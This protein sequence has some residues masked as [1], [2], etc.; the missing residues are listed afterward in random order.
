M[1][2]ALQKSPTIA[3]LSRIALLLFD[4]ARRKVLNKDNLRARL[5]SRADR[6][7]SKVQEVLMWVYLPRVAPKAWATCAHGGMAYPIPFPVLSYPPLPDPILDKPLMPALS[8]IRTCVPIFV[9]GMMMVVGCRLD[10][11]WLSLSICLP[12]SR[13][14]PAG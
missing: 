1:E 4:R 12:L 11:C 2:G 6:W 13:S 5:E 8:G 10:Y 9:R 3:R 14:I 7:E